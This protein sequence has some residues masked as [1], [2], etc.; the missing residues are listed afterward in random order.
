MM[1]A[2]P[3][4]EV[5]QVPDTREPY[6]QT[7]RANAGGDP[8]RSDMMVESPEKM[9]PE[10]LHRLS[11]QTALAETAEGD[12]LLPMAGG[13][14]SSLVPVRTEFSQNPGSSMTAEVRQKVTRAVTSGSPNSPGKVGL[15]QQVTKAC[16][17]Q[18]AG[19]SCIH[20][21]CTP[22]RI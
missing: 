1:G 15:R 11:G 2:T 8:T 6:D 14:Q 16:W 9:P 18:G 19:R 12:S 21:I 7:L 20:K 4:T 17:S 5:V 22:Q 13:P 10:K 3:F